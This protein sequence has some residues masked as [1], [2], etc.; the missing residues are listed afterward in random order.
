M[1][2]RRGAPPARGDDGRS[3][4][5]QLGELGRGR[6]RLDDVDEQAVRVADHEVALPEGSSRSSSSSGAPSSSA[7]RRIARASSTSTVTR[8]PRGAARTRRDAVVV[9]GDRGEL[10]SSAGAASEMYQSDSYVGSSPS[11]AR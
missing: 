9:A 4:H 6:D 8:V 2:K 3:A 5:V 7:R 10:G 1:T 11:S